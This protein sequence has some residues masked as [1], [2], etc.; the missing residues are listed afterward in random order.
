MK[1]YFLLFALLN[2]FCV[3]SVSAQ[4]YKFDLDEE[5]FIFQDDEEDFKPISLTQNKV[6]IKK[7]SKMELMEPVKLKNPTKE[8]WGFNTSGPKY[9]K[10]QPK[11][12]IDI[13]PPAPKKE[14]SEKVVEAKPLSKKDPMVNIVQ[15]VSKN[16]EQEKKV[17]E[18]KNEN[19]DNTRTD[20]NISEAK[21]L[22]KTA[23]KLANSVKEME[24]KVQE[25]VKVDVENK[26]DEVKADLVITF[27]ENQEDVIDSN[28]LSGVIDRA[29]KNADITL[30][31]T[32]YYVNND[33]RNVAFSRLLN[34]R[35]ILLDK[36]VP[37]SQT[38]IM[39]LEDETPQHT[40]NNTIE[41]IVIENK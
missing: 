28:I 33:N 40:K 11:Y 1:K 7:I 37:T 21:E 26:I 5:F 13:L 29:L 2:I 9:Q 3:N 4:N 31:L 10:S 8:N 39:V 6:N 15:P 17:N 23:E 35:K 22:L 16:I 38:M 32:S 27:N 19:F 18:I 25:K 14:K 20:K 41:I 30:K 12:V 24:E 34:T 36:G